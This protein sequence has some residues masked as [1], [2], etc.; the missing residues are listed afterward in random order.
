MLTWALV[1][2]KQEWNTALPYLVA[3]GCDVAIFYFA[4]EGIIRGCRP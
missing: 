3:M 2:A 1:V 4:V